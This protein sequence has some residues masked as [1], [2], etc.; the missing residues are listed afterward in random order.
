MI[1]REVTII[2]ELNNLFGHVFYTSDTI[3][4]KIKGVAIRN[5]VSYVCLIGYANYFKSNKGEKS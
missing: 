4:K 5:V 1:K 2:V 3:K